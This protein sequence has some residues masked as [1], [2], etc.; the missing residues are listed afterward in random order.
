MNKKY[1]TFFDKVYLLEGYKDLRC[2]YR[3][4]E[5]CIDLSIIFSSFGN[6]IKFIEDFESNKHNYHCCN[7]DYELEQKE[8]YNNIEFTDDHFKNRQC[9]YCNKEIEYSPEWFRFCIYEYKLNDKDFIAFLY[10][11]EYIYKKKQIKQRFGSFG[12][13][14][15]REVNAAIL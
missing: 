14:T 13:F 9:P 12:D 3:G 1:D 15:Y 7:C 4:H 5:G 6:A 8:Q 2:G 11:Y 10:E